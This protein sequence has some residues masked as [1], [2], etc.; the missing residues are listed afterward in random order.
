MELFSS[1]TGLLGF[2]LPQLFQ[3]NMKITV[4]LSL[5][6]LRTALEVLWQDQILEEQV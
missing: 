2:P 1:L 5:A 4:L 3:M 6:G